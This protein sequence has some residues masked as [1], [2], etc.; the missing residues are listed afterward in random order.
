MTAALSASAA[1]TPNADAAIIALSDRCN[2]CGFCQAACP[3][4]RHTVD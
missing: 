3:S 4:N 1:A 2:R